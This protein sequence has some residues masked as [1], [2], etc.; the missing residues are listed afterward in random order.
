M[1]SAVAGIG[2]VRTTCLFQ[3]TS[4]GTARSGMLGD[5]IDGGRRFRAVKETAPAPDEL[6]LT[7]ALRNRQVVERREPNPIG[8]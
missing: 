2:V 6:D 3:V 8:F 1:D 4:Q 5:V 7:D